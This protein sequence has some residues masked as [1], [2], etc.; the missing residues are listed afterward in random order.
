MP[1][2]N[3]Q[4][5]LKSEYDDTP[6][7]TTTTTTNFSTGNWVIAVCAKIQD[8]S[9]RHFR[10]CLFNIFSYVNEGLET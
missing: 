1:G 8:G 3:M 2:I 7:T 4:I 5:L 9:C 6:L 10:F